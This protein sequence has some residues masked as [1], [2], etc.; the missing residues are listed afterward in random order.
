MNIEIKDVSETRKSLVVTLDQAEVAAEH[1]A[2][3]GEISKQARLPGFRP[4][5][6][7]AAMIIKRY[8]KEISEE[9]KQKVMSKAYRGGLEQSK[10]EALNITDVQEGTIAV[11]Q[12]ATITITLDVRPTFTLPDYSNLS[13]EIQ[14]VEST[15]AEVEKVIE[16]MRSERADFKVA[17]RAAAKADYVKLAYEGTI[18]GQSILEIVA[19]KQIYAKVPQ[20]WEEVEGE[21]EG[22]IPGLGKQLAGLSKGNKKDITISFPAEFAAVPAL[23]GKT[24]VYAVEILEIRERVLPPMD[25]AFFKANQS[26]NLDSLKVNVRNNL[27]G[28]KEYENRQAQRRQVSEALNAKVEFAIPESLVESETQS[29]LR[30]FIEENMRRG[31]PAEQFEKDKAALHQ[32]ASVAARTRVK[33]QLLLAKIAEQEKITVNER[34]IDT[35]IYRESMMTQQ[36]PEKLVKELTKDREKLRSIQQS[37]IFDKALDLLV[38]KATVT[39]A[40]AKA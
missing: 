20:T 1:K 35:F 14:S 28:R 36:K 40:P 4:G 17:E 32:S 34:D 10:L 31:V 25:E 12:P 23:A 37:I 9:F 11:D 5:K 30:Q 13:T 21:N 24:A 15:D 33:T 39:T 8:S 19:D 27:K 2:V 6:A 29:V 38:S 26:D 3:V 16:G 22:L 7:P 18:D